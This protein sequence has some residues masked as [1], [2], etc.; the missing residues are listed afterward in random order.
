M[1]AADMEPGNWS[2]A[3]FLCWHG[4]CRRQR[5]CLVVFLQ[6]IDE[7]C[8]RDGESCTISSYGAGWGFSLV[9]GTLPLCK[10]RTYV[11]AT[12]FDRL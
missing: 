11:Q 3:V 5:I 7:I 4:R 9:S 12:V 8:F 10:Y 6:C 1:R 2:D